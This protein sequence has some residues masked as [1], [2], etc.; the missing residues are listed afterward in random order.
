VSSC[1]SIRHDTVPIRSGL[2]NRSATGLRI[3][4]LVG[5]KTPCFSYSVALNKRKIGALVDVLGT[6]PECRGHRVGANRNRYLGPIHDNTVGNHEKPAIICCDL[7]RI[8][9]SQYTFRP[10]G[11]ADFDARIRESTQW[12]AVAETTTSN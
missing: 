4:V 1:R 5:R 3:Y 11:L 10:Q 8:D 9:G 2:R 12:K 7:V 6:W